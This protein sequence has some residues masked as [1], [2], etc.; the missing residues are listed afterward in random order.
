VAG[1]ARAIEAPTTST[2]IVAGF[3][4]VARSHSLRPA[5]ASAGPI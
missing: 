2:V 1:V 5:F 4:S 3:F